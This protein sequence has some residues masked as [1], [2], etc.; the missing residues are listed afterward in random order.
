MTKSLWLW[1]ILA[2][3]VLIGAWT[4]LVIIAKRHQPTKIELQE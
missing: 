4:T 1:V 2:F 3:L